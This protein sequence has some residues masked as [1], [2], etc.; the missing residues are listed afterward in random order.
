MVTALRV[1]NDQG[2]FHM[3]LSRYLPERLSLS[4]KQRGGFG[5]RLSRSLTNKVGGVESS[6]SRFNVFR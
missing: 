5:R 6:T 4:P 1:N 2:I 3:L